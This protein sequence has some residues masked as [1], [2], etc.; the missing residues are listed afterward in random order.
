M[1]EKG[2]DAKDKIIGQF[3]VGF[4]SVFIVSDGVEVISRSS[5]SKEA[6][7]WFINKYFIY[8]YKLWKNLKKK[9][10]K[11]KENINKLLQ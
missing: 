8:L 4:Y 7:S 6:Y 1:E 11:K 5:D 9:L 10:E 2:T 3:G